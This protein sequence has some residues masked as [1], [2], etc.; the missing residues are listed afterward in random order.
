MGDLN[1]STFTQP[2]NVSIV[3]YNGTDHLWSKFAPPWVGTP[4]VRGTFDILESCIFTL[5]ACVFTALHLDVI[6]NPTWQRLLLE[7]I[8]WVLL[9]I[10]VPEISLLTA[11]NQ[12]GC[13]WA[14]KS[15]LKKIQKQ[16]KSSISSPEADFEI[17]LK[18]AYFIVMG[19]LRF[20]VNDILSIPDLDP[21][22]E[23]L[24]KDPE[25]QNGR[26]PVRKAVR[27]GPP[28]IVALA[29]KGHWIKVLEKDID[30]KSKA[31]IFQKVLVLIQVLWMIMQCVCRFVFGLPLTLLEIHTMLHVIFAIIQYCYWIKKPLDVQEPIV[32]QPHGFEAELAI[33]LQKQFY[34]RMS[35]SL[36]LF[37]SR[38][39]P[40]QLPPQ[41]PL[42]SQMRW[43]DQAASAE[44][45]VGDVLPSGLALYRS[46]VLD[47]LFPLEHIWGGQTLVKHKIGSRPKYAKHSFPLTTEFLR[48]WDIILSKYPDEQ[49]ENLAET[50]MRIRQHRCDED[51]ILDVP[52]RE[53]RIL[54]LVRLDEFRQELQLNCER[55]FW[56]GRSFFSL[57]LAP[58][59]ETQGS[60]SKYRPMWKFWRNNSMATVRIQDV[61]NHHEASPLLGSDAETINIP[62][63]RKRR[64][65]QLLCAFAFTLMLADGLQ[66]AGLLQIYES[67]ICNDYYKTHYLEVSK[68]DRCRI[69][70]V[71]K[72]L[73]LCTVPYGLLAERIGRRRVLILSGTAIFASLAWVMA[74]CYWRFAPIRWVLFSGFFLFIGGGDAVASSVVHAMVTDVTDRAERFF[75]PAI[76]VPLME[77]GHSW[78]VLV[79]AEIIIF[80]VTFILPLFIPETLHLR[81]KNLARMVGLC[82]QDEACA[83]TG[84][85]HIGASRQH[86]DI[87]PIMPLAT[88]RPRTPDLCPRAL[89]CHRSI[90]SLARYS[91]S[92]ARGKI[93]LSLFQGAQGLLVL[94]LLPLLTRL[95]AKPRGWTDW[96][97]DRRYV[98]S[99][100]S[101]ISFGLLVI[102]FAPALAI[103]ASG[104]IFVALGSCTTGLFMSLLGGV[105]RPNEISTV[106]SAALTLSMVSR[107]V[108]APVMSV[109]LV[110][111]MELGRVWMG[112]PFVLMAA[113]MTAVTA[114]SGFISPGK[115]DR[116][117]VGQEQGFEYDL[118]NQRICIPGEMILGIM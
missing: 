17:N 55:Y 1:S 62:P 51:G 46:D 103:E 76:S 16:Q 36:A 9:T 108:V 77:K 98:I 85:Y 115:V 6:P 15:K 48:R 5:I 38:Q 64:I 7:K 67:A 70:P 37:P 102:G 91:L 11:S 101:L 20:D 116:E 114:A 40:E 13:A 24:F 66:A 18:Y 59:F 45:K 112:L 107:S 2:W 104:L 34:S 12:I 96:A 52:E 69:Q 27:A 19:G 109:L 90:Y 41:G 39:T 61:E 94:V 53:K 29:N 95:I 86:L 28:A 100:I 32:V 117:S 88:C 49:R 92:Y 74:M 65:I 105:V 68:H 84:F 43:I 97:R 35:Y 14:L 50:S 8:K 21:S 106:Y 113:M 81:N 31:G 79:L 3:N 63:Q 42:G 26:K 111:G 87:K 44:M 33:M 72:E 54:L 57:D 118:V 75:G 82:Q 23:K 4:N 25:P 110:K 58:H 93:L 10:V 80:S 47:A 71:Q 30:D 73:A 83:P 99:S 89:H 60:L 78:T 56:E 22:A